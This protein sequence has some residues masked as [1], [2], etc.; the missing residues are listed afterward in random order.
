MMDKLSGR[1][2]FLDSQLFRAFCLAAEELN[3]TRAA[4][5]AAMTQSGMSQH[6]A[7]LEKQMGAPLFRRI[8]KTVQL[9]EAGNLLFQFIRKQSDALTELRD[10]VTKDTHRFSGT[11]SYAM[12]H[13]CLFTPHFPLLLKKRRGFSEIGLRVELCPNEAVI[14][15]L[16]DGSIDFGFVT[17]RFKNPA[18]SHERFAT[19]EYRIFGSPELPEI[20]LSADALKRIP[21]V[22]YP[23]MD[24]LFEIW[25]EKLLPRSKGIHA[26]DLSIV[27]SINSL[28]G[29]VT[30]VLNGVG[31]TIMPAHCAEPWHSRKKLKAFCSS[32]AKAE[33]DIFIVTL[34][35]A[36][37]PARVER[38]IQS[39]REMKL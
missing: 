26:E 16:L 2:E 33:S 1:F 7:R 28:H 5:K 8:N 34:R 22:K 36:K 3:F 38:V 20:S 32:H 9:T 29:A 35:D 6:I 12:P 24:T 15:G 39:F 13:S 18:V 21:F 11:V 27:G 23:G 19:E 14:G 31:Y 10:H 4:K 25:R 17:R 30:M 37:Q